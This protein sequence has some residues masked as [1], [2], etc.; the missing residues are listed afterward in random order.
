MPPR[1]LAALT[2]LQAALDAPADQPAATAEV[3]NALALLLPL[4]P[5]RWPLDGFWEAAHGTHAIGR[6]QSMN[7]SLNGIHHQM[8]LPYGWMPD[9]GR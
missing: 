6:F 7:A 8:G 3:R 5:E 9:K 2:T 4:C 1:I